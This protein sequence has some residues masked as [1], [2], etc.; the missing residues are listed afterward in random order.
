MQPYLDFTA[1]ETF[2][3]SRRDDIG[4]LYTRPSIARECN[5]FDRRVRDVLS[6]EG[7]T[8]PSH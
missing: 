3:L 1:E 7:E 6:R 5:P 2:K 4:V 8:K